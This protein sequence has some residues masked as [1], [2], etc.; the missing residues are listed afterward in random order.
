MKLASIDIGTNTLRLLIG[1]VDSDGHIRDTVLE[2]KI[3]RL[4]GGFDG[5]FLHPDAK[6]RTLAALRQ[7]AKT[8]TQNDVSKVKASATSIAR[9]A[10]D[11]RDF[12][13]E[14][15][16]KTGIVVEI[17]SGNREAALTL[18]GVLSTLNGKERPALIFDIG[19]GSTEYIAAEKGKIEAL[20][21]L[22][23]GVVSL[24]EKHL[25]SD[26]P[27]KSDIS[28]ISKTVEE[29]LDHLNAGLPEL[30]AVAAKP[31]AILVGTAGT[32]TTLAAI[33][34]KLDVYDSRKINNYI[35]TKTSVEALFE[36][37]SARTHSERAAIAA[38]E[39]GRADLIIPGAIIVL[40][41]M[42]RFGL[43]ELVVSDYGLLEGLLLDLAEQEDLI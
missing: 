36:S 14:I 22:Q 21:S 18:K 13:D 1:E 9:E 4:G 35:L 34:Q 39:E 8:L 42:E 10:L 27:A 11:G 43:D 12:I 37:L 16:Q 26:P 33:D 2:R 41:T 17:I 38:L 3:T 5:R 30:A 6:R 40:K 20:S 31:G 25:K 19:G 23:M 28:A 24:A 15:R 7:F 29:F 32:V